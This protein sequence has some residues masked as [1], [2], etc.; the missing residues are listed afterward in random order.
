VTIESEI[1]LDDTPSQI[2][3]PVSGDS[4]IANNPFGMSLLLTEIIPSTEIA[5]SDNSKFR[6]GSSVR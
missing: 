5:D 1:G 4:F 2:Y 3:L 6:A